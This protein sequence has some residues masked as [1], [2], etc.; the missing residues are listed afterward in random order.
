MGIG[1][2]RV[3]FAQAAARENYNLPVARGWESKSVEAQQAEASEKPS[4]RRSPMSVEEAARWREKESLRLSRQRVLEQLQAS[5]N[6]RH[7]KLIEDTLA[8]LDEKLRK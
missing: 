1:V 4:Q 7:R 8:D 3:A 6:P 5:Q 2:G